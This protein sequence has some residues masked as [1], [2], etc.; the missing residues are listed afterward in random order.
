VLAR[1]AYD[2]W[3]R[4]QRRAGLYCR[5]MLI[6]G[7]DD[8][9]E[10]LFRLLDEHPEFGF[11]AIGMVG[12]R[13]AV[14]MPAPWLGGLD[15]LDGVLAR[16]NPNGVMIT[17]ACLPIRE[18]S[19][20]I[21]DLSRRGL[22]VHVSGGLWGIDY[23]RVRPAPVAHEPLL[24]IE[25]AEFGLGK[26]LMKRVGDI[27]ISMIVLVLASPFLAIA[28][29]A[30]WFADRG[31]VL[32][33]QRRVGKD[34]V[35]FTL[36]KLRTMRVGADQ[37]VDIHLNGREGPLYKSSGPDARVTKVG[38]ILRLTSFDE[39]PQLF[40]VLRGQMSLVGPRPALPHEVEQFDDELMARL[41]AVPGVTGLWQVEARDNPSFWAYRR[42]DLF[43][44][45]NWSIV[46]DLV[47]LLLT[48]EAV[49][50]RSLRVFTRT[51]APD[52]A[53]LQ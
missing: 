21:G 35:E 31:P 52:V 13:P 16:S 40:N 24:Y 4:R 19:A 18:K 48:V 6:V 41:S 29:A 26:R 39:L 5:P 9:A 45:E 36:Y 2:G 47:I 49:I 23:R 33:S 8:E 46:L 43:Y 11:T 20:L 51:S 15:D 38:S 22:H 34:G 28:A 25:N 7:T 42:L 37:E 53:N 3:L 44:V 14:H 12:P 32:Y 17:A 10:H 1:A 27:I 30:I 50:E